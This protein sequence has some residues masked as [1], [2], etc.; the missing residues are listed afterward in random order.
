[1]SYTRIGHVVDYPKTVAY[2][3]ENNFMIYQQTKTAV[4]ILIIKIG[5]QMQS[6]LSGLTEISI[7]NLF[8]LFKTVIGDRKTHYLQ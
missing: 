2:K 4:S 7:H 3:L 8:L 1:M 6:Y 5:V